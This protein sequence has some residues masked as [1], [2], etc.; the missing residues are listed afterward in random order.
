MASGY[1]GEKTQNIVIEW[2]EKNST[3]TI[4][5]VFGLKMDKS[6]YSLDEIILN[7]SAALFT[8]NDNSTLKL[9]HAARDFETWLHRSYLSDNDQELPLYQ[10]KNRNKSMGS[11][12]IKH[13][14]LEAFHTEDMW[15]FSHPVKRDGGISTERMFD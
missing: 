15:H 5:L 11:L 8:D 14:Q 9:K 1:C 3:N 6:V 2:M 4:K 10:I 7:V 13:I 12:V